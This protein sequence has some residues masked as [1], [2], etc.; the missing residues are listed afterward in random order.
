MFRSEFVKNAGMETELQVL[1]DVVVAFGRRDLWNNHVCDK[2][3]SR[4]C[5][6]QF[7]FG[8]LQVY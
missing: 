6:D 2:L 8:Y 7:D 3:D 5:Y 1:F 4:A